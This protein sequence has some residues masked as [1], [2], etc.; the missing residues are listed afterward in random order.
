MRKLYGGKLYWK[1]NLS[2]TYS[3]LNKIYIIYYSWNNLGLVFFLEITRYNLIRVLSLRASSNA[4]HKSLYPEVITAL[5]SS[6]R[7]EIVRCPQRRFL[8][9]PKRYCCDKDH[10]WRHNYRRITLCPAAIVIYVYI[11]AYIMNAC[12]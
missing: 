3:F 2:T 8:L 12:K 5:C 6:L 4:W 7:C 11:G 1:K 9:S 10:T